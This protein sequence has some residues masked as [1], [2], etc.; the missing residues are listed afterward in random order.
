MAKFRK[1]IFWK[2]ATWTVESG[3]RGRPE[4][5]TSRSNTVVSNQ[6]AGTRD[7]HETAASASRISS[8]SAATEAP[9]SMSHWRSPATTTSC[10]EIGIGSMTALYPV[11]SPARSVSGGETSGRKPMRL[12]RS[13]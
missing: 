13:R 8:H 12:E 2:P 3:T 7:V 4:T 6:Y 9:A 11:S 1:G 10:N 5:F